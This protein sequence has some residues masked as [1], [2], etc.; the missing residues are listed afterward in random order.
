MH[1]Y[2]GYYFELNTAATGVAAADRRLCRFNLMQRDVAMP[3]MMP[4]VADLKSG[5][6]TPQDFTRIVTII[7]SYLF[8]RTVVGDASNALNKI[9]ATLYNEATRIRTENTDLAEVISY[10]LLKR[11]ETS[12]R[13]PEDDEFR[14]EFATRN[15]YKFRSQYRQYIFE[16]LENRNSKDHLDVA[17]ALQDGSASIGRD[18]GTNQPINRASLGI[19]AHVADRVCA[20]CRTV[21]H[22]AA[23]GTHRF[24]TPE[25]RFL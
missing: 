12:G 16:C 11:A 18:R 25:N 17:N 1:Q 5:A 13:F 9:F 14:L 22:R 23:W 19:L 6:I 24:Q 7:D 3:T 10:L 15:F 21:A 8:R 4:L 2:S 20:G